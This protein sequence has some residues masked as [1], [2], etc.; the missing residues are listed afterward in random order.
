MLTRL[1]ERRAM[2]SASVYNYG[3][4]SRQTSLS[5]I[6]CAHEKQSRLSALHSRIG[7]LRTSSEERDKGRA[8][9][10][11]STHYGVKDKFGE[12]M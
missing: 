10:F 2:P 8:V 5:P 7:R 1:Q 4:S 11:T 9:N 12:S 3:Q 6:C